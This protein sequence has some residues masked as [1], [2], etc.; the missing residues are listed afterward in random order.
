[1][2]DEF[3]KISAL[4]YPVS[5]S[6]K[7]IFLSSLFIAFTGYLFLVVF[8]PFGADSFQVEF[9][10]LLLLPYPLIAFVAYSA[11]NLALKR[12]FP[13]NLKQELGKIFF[14]LVLCS[15][16][17]YVYNIYFIN[18]VSFDAVHF[19]LMFFYTFA[20]AV[21]VS[22]IYVLGRYLYL[23]RYWGKAVDL[24]TQDQDP[25]LL[26]IVP[27][28]GS[29]PVVMAESHFLFA[30]SDGNYTSIHFLQDGK[31]VKSLLRLSLKNL[32][33]QLESRKIIRCH[34]SYIVNPDRVVR[35]KGNAQGY[36]L[37]VEAAGEW[38][39]VSRNY[40]SRISGLMPA[41]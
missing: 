2:L 39:P 36:K 7:E 32:E 5:Q 31:S 17:N 38:V 16:G 19:L 9:K 29:D 14:I 22:M 28:S 12:R 24:K 1:M 35:I 26:H 34:R 8:Q 37:Y 13:W 25:D 15:L 11:V 18:H 27:E 30:I 4:P 21:P 3:R 33:A 23:R 6:R 40:I 20:I 41:G 10:Y